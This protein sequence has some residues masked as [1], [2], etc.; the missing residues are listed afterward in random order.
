MIL[1]RIAV[2]KFSPAAMSLPSKTTP[3]LPT[4]AISME[5]QSSSESDDDF[6][7]ELMSVLSTIGVLPT[8]ASFQKKQMKDR[9]GG[10]GLSLV[11][12]QTRKE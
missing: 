6:D 12:E 1:N 9:G 11:G 5:W 10:A 7:K 2:G 4:C 3:R 8:G